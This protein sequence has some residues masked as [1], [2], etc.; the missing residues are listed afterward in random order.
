MARVMI[1]GATDGIGL[2]TARQLL[3]EGHAVLLYGRDE[4]R[5]E[6]VRH[7]DSMS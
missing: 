2:E 3:A 6:A 7:I 1:T 4:A 5:A